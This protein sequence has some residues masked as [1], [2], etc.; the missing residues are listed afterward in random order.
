MDTAN[1][2]CPICSRPA[3]PSKKANV[4]DPDTSTWS[5]ADFQRYQEKAKA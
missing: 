5:F 2:L 1:V 4:P 3:H